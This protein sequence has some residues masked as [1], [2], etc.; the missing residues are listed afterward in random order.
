MAGFVQGVHGKGI[1]TM[2]QAGQVAQQK[3]MA[4]KSKYMEQ[5]YGALK[6]QGEEWMAANAKKLQA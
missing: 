2:E 3:M 5:K 4:I 6:K 1:M